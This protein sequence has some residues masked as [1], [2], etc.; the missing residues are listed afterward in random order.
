[1]RQS[2]AEV[3]REVS[4]RTDA[5]YALCKMC[6]VCGTKIETRKEAA[7]TKA[8]DGS[9]F[10]SHATTECTEGMLLEVLRRSSFGRRGSLRL[11]R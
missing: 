9:E 1:M 5:L 2:V 10:L 8:A 11:M 4:E 3:R 7:H 6:Q